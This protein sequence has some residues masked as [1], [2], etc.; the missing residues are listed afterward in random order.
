LLTLDLAVAPANLPW[1]RLRDDRNLLGKSD[2]TLRPSGRPDS[3]YVH[4]N[5]LGFGWKIGGGA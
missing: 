1:E 3:P 5:S 2:V 4:F